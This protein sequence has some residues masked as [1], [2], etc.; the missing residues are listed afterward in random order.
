MKIAD[1]L[2]YAYCN[3]VVRGRKGKLLSDLELKNLSRTRS[4]GESLNVLA[5]TDYRDTLKG[6]NYSEGLK[7]KSHLR[8]MEKALVQKLIKEEKR[9]LK[10]TLESLQ[11]ILEINLQRWEV[12]NIKK[13]LRNSFRKTPRYR[14]YIVPYLRDNIK[15]KLEEV[16]N[17]DNPKEGADILSETEYAFLADTLS[18]VESE[19]VL[20]TAEMALDNFHHERLYEKSDAMGGT[21]REFFGFEIDRIN[22]ETAVRG[23]VNG[24]AFEDIEDYFLKTH[25]IDDEI[26]E[27]IVESSGIQ[28]ALTPLEDTYME[29]IIQ[30]KTGKKMSFELLSENLLKKKLD[31]ANKIYTSEALGPGIILGYLTMKDI[32]VKNIIRI[33]YLKEAKW[34]TEKILSAVIT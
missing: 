33:L 21:T 13:A 8:E 4:I 9:I 27:A 3:A 1:T 15:E 30:A 34:P 16:G 5:N 18:S 28:S 25:N 10:Y 20:F 26:L 24:I 32:E 12:R 7:A 22:I 29:D 17:A 6:I 2:T 31:I 11:A 23:S 14:E 19:R